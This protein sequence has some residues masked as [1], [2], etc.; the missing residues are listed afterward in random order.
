MKNFRYLM[1]RGLLILCIVFSFVQSK[2]IY[3]GKKRW[4]MKVYCQEVKWVSLN[5]W[6]KFFTA[7]ARVKKIAFRRAEKKARIASFGR[8]KK[9]RYVYHGGAKVLKKRGRK[10]L[11]R[12]KFGGYKYTVKN[13]RGW[14]K[15]YYTRARTKSGA[16]RNAK[17]WVK[18]KCGCRYSSSANTYKFKSGT[19][20][21]S[22]L[23]I[24]KVR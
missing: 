8:S 5:G 13:V 6:P 17:K 10:K 23:N 15:W 19:R 11:W 4:K 22:F 16:K 9:R 7:W 20:F 14:P 3:A 12:F 18:R 1:L 21:Y 2:K 24:R